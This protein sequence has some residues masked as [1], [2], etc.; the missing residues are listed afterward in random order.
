MAKS[1]NHTTHNQGHKNH[2]NGIKKPK[3][4]V[5]RSLE[6]VDPKFLKNQ[7]FAKKH[8]IRVKTAAKKIDVAK[9]KQIVATT[10]KDTGSVKPI[11][12][13]TVTMTVTLKP[14]PS[15]S[16]NIQTAPATTAPVTAPVTASKEVT[17]ADIYIPK[18]KKPTPTAL[19]AEELS[20]AAAAF[21]KVDKDHSGSLTLPELTDLLLLLFA[22]KQQEGLIKRLAQYQMNAADKDKSGSLDFDEFLQVYAF[23]KAEVGKK[24]W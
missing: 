21:G 6:G 13:P 2:R 9:P 1:K 4:K 23:I 24:K 16:K 5:A 10:P 17:A 12:T 11:E 19:T 18:S 22:K 8:N 14:S 15:T 3:R 7:R 20:T